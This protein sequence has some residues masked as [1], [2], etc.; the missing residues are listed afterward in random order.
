MAASS[1]HHVLKLLERQSAARALLSR[2]SRRRE[3]AL[4]PHGTCTPREDGPDVRPEEA[5][6]LPPIRLA[7]ASGSSAAK[8][9]KYGCC[10]CM[11]SAPARPRQGRVLEPRVA[12]SAFV[13]SIY[14]R[15][16]LAHRLQGIT[17]TDGGL[18]VGRSNA[19]IESN[20]TNSTCRIGEN[21]SRAKARRGREKA[22]SFRFGVRVAPASQRE[23]A[24]AHLVVATRRGPRS[25]T[26]GVGAVDNT[27][28]TANAATRARG[29][30]RGTEAK[31]HSINVNVGLER[32][33]RRRSQRP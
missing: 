30:V 18:A 26:Q 17:N 22:K 21:I 5:K 6:R 10:H 13:P 1:I 9:L 27:M 23:E 31:A 29:S 24:I 2:L 25:T 20:K 3:C 32:V 33:P 28:A 7:V 14:S 12:H 8:A 11:L 19:D 4:A 16:P 15:F